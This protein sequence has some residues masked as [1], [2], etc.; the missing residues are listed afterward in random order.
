MYRLNASAVSCFSSAAPADSGSTYANAKN[1]A[2]IT[3]RM[4]AVSSV[5]SHSPNY[6]TLSVALCSPYLCERMWR[7]IKRI[8]QV[9]L[10]CKDSV[11]Q[12][13]P[14]IVILVRH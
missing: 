6:L 4:A 9:S 3:F 5:H 7:E 8:T 13:S 10:D 14:D 11:P 12:E 1:V 2:N